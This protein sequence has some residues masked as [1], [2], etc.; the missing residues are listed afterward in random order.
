MAEEKF[1]VVEKWSENWHLLH[2]LPNILIVACKLFSEIIFLNK[3]TQKSNACKYFH[4]ADFFFRKTQKKL[5]AIEIE[6]WC[7]FV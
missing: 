4:T 5:N 6:S 2:I 3:F 7:F 1:I